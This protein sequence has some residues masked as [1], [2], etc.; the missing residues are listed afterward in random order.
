MAQRFK[1][2]P[3]YWM[4][5]AGK[6][7]AYTGMGNYDKVKEGLR[8]I[9]DNLKDMDPETAAKMDKYVRDVTATLPRR[10]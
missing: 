5:A 6:V 2:T 8:E 3:K 10:P 1:G 4:A 9:N 7:S